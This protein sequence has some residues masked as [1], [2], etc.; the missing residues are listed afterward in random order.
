[1]DSKPDIS[2]VIGGVVVRLC[3]T[4]KESPPIGL[5]ALQVNIG[6]LTLESELFCKERSLKPAC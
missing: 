4:D 5:K 2:H 6:E 3:G 1:M